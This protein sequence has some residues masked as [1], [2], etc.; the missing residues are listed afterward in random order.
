[1]T[2]P[3]IPP[4][5]AP[6]GA[7]APRAAAPGAVTAGAASGLTSICGEFP[8]RIARDGTWYYH[9][10]PIGRKPLVKLFAGVLRRADDGAYQLVTPVERGTIAVD[11]SPFVA[12]LCEASGAGPAQRL[13]F[14]TNLDETVIAGPAHPIRAGGTAESP[15]PYL[16]VRPGLEARIERS[17]YYQLVELG[18]EEAGPRGLAFGVWSDGVFFPLAPSG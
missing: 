4:G 1:M 16:E 13:A 3:S 14:T 6:P 15:T 2:E 9:G 7:R 8:I 17:V 12:V 10:S 11:D 5:A 18:R